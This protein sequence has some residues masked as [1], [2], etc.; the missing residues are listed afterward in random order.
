MEPKA[1]GALGSHQGPPALVQ[2]SKSF[3]KV[4]R[5]DEELA[6]GTATVRRGG[7]HAR[8]HLLSHPSHQE[9]AATG[10]GLDMVPPSTAKR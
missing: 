6:T 2:V 1:R 9:L 4:L 8:A 7:S 10:A 5:W 3:C